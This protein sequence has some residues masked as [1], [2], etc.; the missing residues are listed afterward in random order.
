MIK[1]TTNGVCIACEGDER[2]KTWAQIA[3]WAYAYKKEHKKDK[4]EEQKM[5]MKS[6]RR[7]RGVLEKQAYRQKKDQEEDREYAPYA[8]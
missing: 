8:L 3:W 6:R 5:K 4:A 2:W 7:R 1:Q